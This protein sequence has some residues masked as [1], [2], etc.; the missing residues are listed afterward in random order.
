MTLGAGYVEINLSGVKGT[1]D[2][3]FNGQWQEHPAKSA[4]HAAALF[5]RFQLRTVAVH[6]FLV[7]IEHARRA[8]AAAAVVDV[9]LY[10]RDWSRV[11]RLQFG[12]ADGAA[13]CVCHA[14]QIN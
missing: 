7:Q 11:W 10:R 6:R 12:M 2:A 13:R 14:I 3:Y 8:A 5:P 4:L 1:R 9:G